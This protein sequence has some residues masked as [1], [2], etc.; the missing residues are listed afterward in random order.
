MAAAIQAAGLSKQ[1]RLGQIGHTTLREAAGSVAQ[2]LR[3]RRRRTKPETIWALRD[4]GL[5]IERGEVVGVIGRNGAGK[6]TLLKVLSRITDP[7][8]GAVRIE[9]RVGSLL[10]VGTGFHPDLTGRENVFLNGAIL[11]MR[12]AEVARKF[13][14]I[15]AFSGVE[16]FIDTP[17]KRYSSGMAVRLAFSVAAHLEPEI[18]LVD[19]VLAVGDSEFQRKCLGRMRSIGES[20]RTVLFVSHD[21]AAVGRLCSRVLVFDAGR[22][23]DDGPPEQVIPGF[24]HE[25]W[26]LA[27]GRTWSEEE[28]PGGAAVRLR[29]IRVVDGEG[30]PTRV[31][32]VREP[33]GIE[34]VFE[35]RAAV[36]PFAPWITLHNDR[37]EDVF[38]S[39]DVAPRWRSRP[40]RGRY[41]ATMWIPPHLL[42]EGSHLVSLSLRTEQPRGQALHHAQAHE[43][44]AFQVIDPG[45]GTTARG[46][47]TG[48]WPGPVRP[49]LEWDVEHDRPS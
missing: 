10:E 36:E 29:A 9:G 2:Q 27:T 4:V 22:L 35:V 20:D 34:M 42:N 28:A 24:L 5:Q 6:T 11:G 48:R 19:E 12:R 16:R 46:L 39:M 15:V 47:H 17:V 41:R 23:V 14:E 13:D 32:D 33:A 37:G 30:K 18:L 1:Y 38:S 43:A 40:E 49:L 44:I 8:A 3:A 26:E 25:A 7:S 21:L 45:D 31:V